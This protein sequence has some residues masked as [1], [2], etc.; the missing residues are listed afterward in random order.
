MQIIFSG[1]NSSTG[2]NKKSG[3]GPNSNTSRKSDSSAGCGGYNV[4]YQSDD[5]ILEDRADNS[6]TKVDEL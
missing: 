4:D 3:I 6:V 5:S 1:L 2:T